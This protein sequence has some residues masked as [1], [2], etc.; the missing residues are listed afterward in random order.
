MLMKYE[1]IIFDVDGTLWNACAVSAEGINNALEKLG[2]SK[3]YTAKDIEKYSGE[4]CSQIFHSLFGFLKE[5]YPILLDE[6]DAG[7]RDAILAECGVLYSGVQEGLQK[8]SKDAKLYLVS[9]CQDWYMECFIDFAD[10][11]SFLSGYNSFGA[12][13][14][15]KQ[16]MITQLLNAKDVDHAVYVGDTSKDALASKQ[17]GVDFIGASYGFGDVSEAE[18]SCENFSD[19]VAMLQQS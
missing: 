5:E 18:N 19:I 7:E 12:S 8:L 11:R 16:E 6:A 13:G 14:I 17:A 15:P 9:N 3:R 2:I 4:P 1:H 10:I